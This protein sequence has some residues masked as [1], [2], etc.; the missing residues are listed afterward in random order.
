M[1]SSIRTKLLVSLL[2]GG[3]FVGAAASWIT[4][5][6]TLAQFEEQL[7]KRGRLLGS[8]I[9]HVAMIASGFTRV[10]HVIDKV[11]RDGPELKSIIVVS[12]IR[13]SILASSIK[14]YVG[15]KAR[16]LPELHLRVHVLE[17]LGTGRF[18]QHLDGNGDLVMILPLEARTRGMT[19]HGAGSGSKPGETTGKVMPGMTRK[20][21]TA[22][23]ATPGK[24]A[25]PGAEI[26]KQARQQ[27][28]LGAT[29]T[30]TRDYRGIILLRF[31]YEGV[32]QASFTAVWRHISTLLAA[33][34]VLLV[35]AFILMNRQ[36]L[37]PIA[38][39]RR[40]IDA[41]R[42]GEAKARTPPLGQDEIGEVANLL[43]SM[44]D[45]EDQ[46]EL[47]LTQALVDAKDAKEQAEAANLAK[48]AFLTTMSHELRTPLNAI[49]GFSEMMSKQ[50]FGPMGDPRYIEYAHGIN[51]SGIH[52]LGMINEILDVSKLES[53]NIELH[54]TDCK[55]ED[56]IESV[57]RFIRTQADKGEIELLVEVPEALPLLR[58]DERRVKQILLNLVSNA[59]KFTPPGG[60]VTLRC[61]IIKGRRGMMVEVA[62][63]GIGMTPNDILQ[64][65]IPF[66]QI[67][68]RLTRQYEGTGLGI[69][70]TKSFVELHGGSFE[71]KSDSGTGTTVSVIFPPERVV[72][73]RKAS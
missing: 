36:V 41:R 22:I 32:R 47:Q 27:A 69:P 51:E 14:G 72:L 49:N 70:L 39:I 40:A 21:G 45:T 8:A 6:V 17:S 9:N 30:T 66:V 37:A 29:W 23:R 52:L 50:M 60:R 24:G 53:G 20:S 4:Y 35:I 48:S 56:I 3:L 63:T 71:I 15:Q 44:L 28:Q 18:G 13:P 25:R 10:Q 1:R 58:A 11:V 7:A 31:E 67:E 43:N 68:N 73:Q 46:H 61:A 65:L 5:R 62:D 54:E 19:G 57:I 59:V 16:I 55:V 2:L 38:V 34:L 42:A 12:R 64:A 33:V 26:G